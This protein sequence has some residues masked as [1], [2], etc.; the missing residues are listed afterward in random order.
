MNCFSVLL[1][2]DFDCQKFLIACVYPAVVG[3]WERWSESTLFFFISHVHP[4]LSPFWFWHPLNM[5]LGEGD[6]HPSWNFTRLILT[7]T[8]MLTCIKDLHTHTHTYIYNDISVVW[9]LEMNGQERSTTHIL[10]FVEADSLRIT[11]CTHSSLN[12]KNG[13]SHGRGY[14]PCGLLLGMTACH[15]WDNKQRFC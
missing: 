2:K 12:E 13:C 5:D 9:H 6:G 15:T 3:V 10:L 11:F 7:L 14:G 8:C 4:T 1:E